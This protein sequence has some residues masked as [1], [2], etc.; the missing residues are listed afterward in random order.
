MERPVAEAEG[1]PSHLRDRKRM[2]I[3]RENKGKRE[4]CSMRPPARLYLSAHAAFPFSFHSR[5]AAAAL[6]YPFRESGLEYHGTHVFAGTRRIHLHSCHDRPHRRTESRLVC[7][8]FSVNLIPV[9]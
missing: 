5:I 2:I 6:V 1:K 3:E 7:L 8:S 4:E 9:H